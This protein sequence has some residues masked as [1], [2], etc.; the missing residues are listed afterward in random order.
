MQNELKSNVY[1]PSANV[2]LNQ[3]YVYNCKPNMPQDTVVWHP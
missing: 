2:I 1:I 3:K